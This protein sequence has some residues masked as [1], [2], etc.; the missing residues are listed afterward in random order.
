MARTREW[1]KRTQTGKRTNEHELCELKDRT[2]YGRIPCRM[3]PSCLAGLSIV[4]VEDHDDAL[5]GVL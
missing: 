5:L 2:S 1:G 4:V 3:S